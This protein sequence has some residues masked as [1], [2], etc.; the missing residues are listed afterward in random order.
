MFVCI[1]DEGPKEKKGLEKGEG[2]E[3]TGSGRGREVGK[4]S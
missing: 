1:Y 4:E 2:E 3:K